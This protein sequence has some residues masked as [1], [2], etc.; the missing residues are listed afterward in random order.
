VPGA[1]FVTSDVSVLPSENRAQIESTGKRYFGSQFEVVHTTLARTQNAFG[2]RVN[3]SA[4]PDSF[5][6][7]LEDAPERV[8]IASITHTDPAN[9]KLLVDTILRKNPENLG[10]RTAL[11]L[12]LNDK[13]TPTG[14]FQ[15]ETG[16]LGVFSDIES[17]CEATEQAQDFVVAKCIGHAAGGTNVIF[18][19]P[20]NIQKE[21]TRKALAATLEQTNLLLFRYLR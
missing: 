14:L 3:Q 16:Y 8:T 11:T 12:A 10:A 18:L 17:I 13:V 19:T 6:Q 21:K 1:F 5:A 2:L 9:A 7:N 20:E 15:E 4:L